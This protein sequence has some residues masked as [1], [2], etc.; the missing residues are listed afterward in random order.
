MLDLPSLLP[1]CCYVLLVRLVCTTHCITKTKYFVLYNILV[2]TIN[3][4]LLY[5]IY[6][7]NMEGYFF[8]LLPLVVHKWHRQ[9]CGRCRYIWLFMYKHYPSPS[10]LSQRNCLHFLLKV[11]KSL[12]NTIHMIH[13]L[14]MDF[15]LFARTFH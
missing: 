15:L 8:R 9:T 5:Y 2:N 11:H 13:I 14:W 3:I 10:S 1:V 7:C 6:M 4:D 12:I